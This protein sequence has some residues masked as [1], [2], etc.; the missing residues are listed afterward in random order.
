MDFVDETDLDAEIEDLDGSR[1]EEDSFVERPPYV[2]EFEVY[3]DPTEDDNEGKEGGVST[4][5]RNSNVVDQ[6]ISAHTSK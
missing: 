5:N 6:F 2:R 4:L 3:I 1:W